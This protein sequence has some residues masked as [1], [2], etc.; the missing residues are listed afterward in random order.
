MKSFLKKFLVMTLSQGAEMETFYAHT[1]V[2]ADETMDFL[3]TDTHGVYVDAT[4]GGGGHTARLLDRCSADA[5]VYGVDQDEEAL[6]AACARLDHDPRFR[7]VRGNFEFLETLLPSELHGTISGFLFDFGVSTHQIREPE[8]GFSFMHEGPLDMRMSTLTGKTA[9]EIVNLGSYEYLRDLLYHKGEERKSREIARSIIASRPLHST[10]DLRRA[11]EAVV[12]GP[13]TIKSVARV[14]QAI[15]I[16]VNRELEVIEHAL[17][18]S[19]R[20]LKTGGRIVAISYHSLEDRLV[21]N[22]FKSGNFQGTVEKDFYG[23]PMTPFR[24]LTKKPVVAGDQERSLNPASRSA[25][26]RA[27]EKIVEGGI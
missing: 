20:L 4:L 2:L 15:R 19:L 5:K 18:Q 6:N 21:K 10:G 11:V 1:P 17:E 25:K 3:C 24:L 16:E 12:K 22:F 7:P 8:R 13:H 9:L 23:H 14:F 26:L 27:A